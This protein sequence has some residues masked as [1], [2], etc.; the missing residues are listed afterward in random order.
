M[1]SFQEADKFLTEKS[2]KEIFYRD[3]L[4]IVWAENV[5]HK[6]FGHDMLAT[7]VAALSGPFDEKAF[8]DPAIK[9]L[10]NWCDY[11]WD[12]NWGHAIDRWGR[13]YCKTH[14]DMVHFNHMSA[15]IQQKSDEI[16]N[17][18][19]QNARDPKPLEYYFPEFTA[20]GFMNGSKWP[21]V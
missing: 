12:S 20:F 21:R 2:A 5:H 11:A 8:D 7:L 6:Q 16:Y 9:E 14:Q 13:K 15:M 17:Y 4:Y 10:L 19:S 1:L 3:V 18:L